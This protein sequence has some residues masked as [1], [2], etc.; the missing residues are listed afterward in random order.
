MLAHKGRRDPEVKAERSM[1]VWVNAYDVVIQLLHLVSLTPT[2]WIKPQ[3][4]PSR[5]GILV[6]PLWFRPLRES[7][8]LHRWP[9]T[10]ITNVTG[11]PIQSG[12]LQ[13]RRAHK[14]AAYT[15]RGFARVRCRHGM[16]LP[17]Q[18]TPDLSDLS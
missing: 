3:G 7:H 14:L 2:L 12:P 9:S 8:L 18:D 15:Q 13:R 10:Q 5:P 4:H 11:S 1:T 16:I 6:L 17:F